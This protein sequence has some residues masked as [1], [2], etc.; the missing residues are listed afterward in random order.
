MLIIQGI[1]A[2]IYGKEKIKDIKNQDW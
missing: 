1:I 2:M